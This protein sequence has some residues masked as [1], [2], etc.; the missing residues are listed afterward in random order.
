MDL[1]QI[2][3]ACLIT[4]EKTNSSTVAVFIDERLPHRAEGCCLTSRHKGEV[5]TRT[6][7]AHDWSVCP[8]LL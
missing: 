5:D 3:G 1:L 8:D 4:L 7:V 2:R 6:Q